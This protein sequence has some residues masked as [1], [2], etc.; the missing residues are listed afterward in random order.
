[1]K[2]AFYFLLPLII[3]AGGCMKDQITVSDAEEGVSVS[4]D[5]L[6]ADI[7]VLQ[8]LITEIGAGST[9]TSYSDGKITFSSGTTVTVTARTAYDFSYENPVVSASGDYWSLDGTQLSVKVAD[10]AIKLKG[11]DGAWYVY[12]SSSWHELGDVTSGSSIPVFEAVSE[13]SS[14]GAVSVTLSDGTVLSVE[15]YQGSDSI[16]LNSTSATVDKAGGAVVVTVTSSDSWTATVSDSWLSLNATSGSSGDK[17]TATASANTGS[18]R[19]ATAT[20]TCGAVSATLTVTQSGETDSITSS[21]TEQSEDNVGTVSFDRTISITFS[22]S[23]SAS[24]SGDDNGVVTVSGN[25]VTVKNADYDEKVIYELSGTTSDGFFKLY[26]AN[27]QAIVLNG[28]SITNK[29]GAAINVQSNKRTFVVV[30]GTNKLADGSSYSDTPSDE[31]EKAA[32]FSEGQLIFSGSG[33]LSV[34]ATGKAGITSDDYV[35]F[36]SSPTVTVN[37]TA[38][39]G[40]RGKDAVTVSNGMIDITVSAAGKKGISSDGTVTFDGGETDITVSGGVDTSDSSDLS[41]SAGIKSDGIFTMN[42]GSLTITNSGQGGKGISGDVQGY[43][44]GGTVSVTVS[45][46]NYGSSGGNQF[47]K[48]SSSSDN[49]VAAKGIKF[50]GDLAIT[51]GNISAVAKNHEAIES[52]GT[53]E[54]SGGYTY[55]NSS[56]DAI[57]AASHLTITDGYVCAYST[58][59]DGIDSNGNMYIKGGVI[60]A[61][62]SGGAEVAL[63]ANTEGGYKLYVS[64]GTLFALG[65]LEN[66]AT[67]TQSCYSGSWSS[68][69]W[70]SM[71]VGSST[72]A[73]KTPSSGGTGLVVSGSS[74]PTVKSGVSVSGGTSIF[75]GMGL[76]SPTVSGG[77]SLSLSTYSGGSSSGGPGGN[78]GGP[79]GW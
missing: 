6:N 60:Y 43:F 75:N 58:G 1:M 50:D 16:E 25:D 45:G 69:T 10:E 26:S 40:V 34:T 55:A 35:R 72:Y 31:D 12:Y 5:V 39:H 24:V 52:K 63:D 79:G 29:S 61:I 42:S 36:M 53:I 70:Y 56:D 51:G 9:V 57:N 77:S 66:G 17:V 4:C 7:A 32:L 14:T 59:N 11:E 13:S 38:G 46:S 37:S 22:S 62:C 15:A 65:S 73:F 28:V 30:N 74:Q 48:A 78:G 68:N 19:T 27:K 20:F 2:R 8:T 49:S 21:D 23:G 71:T 67:L 64:G 54:I 3:L 33:S 47:G 44:N 76:I 18:K 41:G